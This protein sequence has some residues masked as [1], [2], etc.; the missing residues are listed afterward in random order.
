MADFQATWM[1][2]ANALTQEK[3]DEVAAMSDEKFQQFLIDEEIPRTCE[4]FQLLNIPPRKSIYSRFGDGRLH[5]FC[6]Y[7]INLM[8]FFP[9]NGRHMEI[10][11]QYHLPF[12]IYVSSR[13]GFEKWI[14]KSNINLFQLYFAQGYTLEQLKGH[15]EEPI[16]YSGN[17]D[18]LDF[19][20]SLETSE[21]IFHPSIITYVCVQRN[22]DMLDRLINKGY[23][24]NE[25]HNGKYPIHCSFNEYY[26]ET[27]ILDRLIMAG[28]DV[29]IDEKI[30][31]RHKSLLLQAF[32]YK[33]TKCFQR[34]LDVG[35]RIYNAVDTE[36]YFSTFTIE[37]NT[38]LTFISRGMDINYPVG[39]STPLEIVKA[40]YRVG[41]KRREA[42]IALISELGGR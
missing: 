42:A 34:L 27:D 8:C 12:D 20:L 41:D 2:N 22:V 33:A 5:S 11:M 35:A 25:K 28:A 9:E 14:E 21:H 30:N 18:V 10:I 3:I 29:N 36:I 16:A 37:H 4:Y 38:L 19:F 39:R 26:D 13:V 24:V 1:I 17:V 31:N 23:S 7:L 15:I 40:R 32:Y 6:M